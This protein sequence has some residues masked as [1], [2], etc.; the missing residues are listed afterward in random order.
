MGRVYVFADEAGNFDFS[1]TQ[2][3]T[4]YFMIGTVT[5]TDLRLEG[6]LLDLRRDLPWQGF[7]IEAA[8]HASED[9]RAVRNEVFKT[10]QGSSFRY[11]VTVF[12]KCKTKPHSQVDEERFYKTAWFLHFNYVAPKIASQK[13]E[14]FVI[15]ATIGTKKRRSIIRAGIEDVVNQSTICSTWNVAFWPAESDPGLQA[16]DYC[17]WAVW[18]KWESHDSRSYALIANK[19]G[20]EFDVFATGRRQY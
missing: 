18:R 14:L 6:Q 7:P 20:T 9:I 4:A 19:I 11:D 17:T 1:R 10:L 5:M 3:A 2:G 12:E 13:D 16:T 8:F 15:A